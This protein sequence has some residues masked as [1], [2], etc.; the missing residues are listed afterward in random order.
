MLTFP[1]GKARDHGG[2]FLLLAFLSL[3]FGWLAFGFLYL[4]LRHRMVVIVASMS[5]DAI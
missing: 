5:P 3:V 2:V 4:V 1:H